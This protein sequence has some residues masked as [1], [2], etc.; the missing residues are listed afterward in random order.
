VLHPRFLHSE[1]C[2]RHG[3]CD[4]NPRR[5]RA[6]CILN[7]IFL[8]ASKLCYLCSTPAPSQH[9]ARRSIRKRARYKHHLSFL[10]SKIRCLFY[11][12][13]FFSVRLTIGTAIARGDR[14]GNGPGSFVSKA[15]FRQYWLHHLLVLRTFHL[16]F[17]AAF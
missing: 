14:Y 12:H 4:G 11:T 10:S 17:E 6:R 1:A 9:R 15:S 3:R 7:T 8:S 13:A 5:K 16:S 2:N